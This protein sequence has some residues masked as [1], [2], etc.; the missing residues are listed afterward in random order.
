VLEEID[1]LVSAIFAA[2][3]QNPKGH[4]GKAYKP[5]AREYLVKDNA[6]RAIV[7]AVSL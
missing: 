7:E 3:S 4:L 2:A 1:E 6:V 5:E